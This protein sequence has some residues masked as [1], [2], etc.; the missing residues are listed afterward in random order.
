MK[1]S[2][3]I[4]SLKFL[5]AEHG[6]IELVLQDSPFNKYPELCKHIDFYIVEEELHDCTEIVI[7]AWPY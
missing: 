6:D 4:E 5:Q 2:E 1:L 3:A 7:R